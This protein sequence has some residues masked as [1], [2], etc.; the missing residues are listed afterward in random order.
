MPL[1]NP[2]HHSAT[3]KKRLQ[4]LTCSLRL[5]YGLSEK[6]LLASPTYKKYL[7]NQMN[8]ETTKTIQMETMIPAATKFLPWRP[9]LVKI[10]GL[11]L[12]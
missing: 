1:K 2:G 5:L 6:K 11:R 12:P 10:H 7:L 4:A 3:N 9:D 8:G